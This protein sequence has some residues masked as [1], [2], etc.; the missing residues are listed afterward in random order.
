MSKDSTYVKKIGRECESTDTHE[1][2]KEVVE[3]VQQLCTGVVNQPFDDHFVREELVCKVLLHLII[4]IMILMIKIK[5]FCT[6]KAT[7]LALK[8]VILETVTVG[9]ANPEGLTIM[10]LPGFDVCTDC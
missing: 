2:K 5:F 7:T 6:S 9:S 10:W 4:I 3:V 1:N 8:S